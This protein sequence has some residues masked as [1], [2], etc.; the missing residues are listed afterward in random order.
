MGAARS[1]KRPANLTPDADLL[2]AARAQG[3][4][5]LAAAEAGLRVAVVLARAERW[6]A[7]NT[8]ALARF[9][10]LDGCPMPVAGRRRSWYD[11]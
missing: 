9:Q 8:A 4:T 3:P 11:Q 1:L 6:Q 2:P 5:H 7:D 10:R